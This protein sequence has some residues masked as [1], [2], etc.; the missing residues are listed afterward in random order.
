MLCAMNAWLPVLAMFF[1]SFLL[2]GIQPMLGRTL[3]PPFG[4]TAAVWTVCLAAYQVLLLVGY[5]Y[6]HMLAQ[7]SARTQRR[8]HL[9]LLALAVVWTF[10][11]AALRLLLKG[12]IGNSAAPS[13][14]VLFCVILFV[15]LPYVLL[16]ANS[17][18]IQAWLART[19]DGGQRTEVGKTKPA[20][21]EQ[22]SVLSPR[23]SDSR[24]VYKL[25][26]VSNFGSLLGLLVYP[27]LLEPFVPLNVQWYG[28]AVCLLAYVLLLAFVA[29]STA[30]R[31]TP[32][33][34]R[35]PSSART[36]RASPRPSP[37]RGCGSRC[38]L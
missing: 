17:T 19:E 15:G 25:Y 5:G 10:G 14:E 31:P 1:G 34:L 8:L 36:P 7:R 18:L 16:S 35:P 38:R 2:F 30:P 26:A 20:G 23:S 33:A 28:F 24:S 11:F 4:G 29:K 37:G 13:L 12:H 3:L 22:S 32:S 6:A 9:G 27:F 21:P